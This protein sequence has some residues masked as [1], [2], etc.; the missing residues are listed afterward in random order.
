MARKAKSTAT[1]KDTK[2]KAEKAEPKYGVSDLCDETGLQAASVRVALRELG[3]EKN[4]GNQYGWDTQKDYKEVVA[5]MKERSAK[6]IATGDAKAK[7]AKKG[8]KSKK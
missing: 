2:P 5:A 4:F 6:R 7:P 8:Q 1:K 3:V